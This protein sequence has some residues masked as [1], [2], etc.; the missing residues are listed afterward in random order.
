MFGVD[1]KAD[2]IRFTKAFL[3]NQFARLTPS[4]YVKYTKETGRGLKESSA[5]ETA[6]YF[7]LC[8]FEYFKYLNISE[9]NIPEYL[10]DKYI[11]EYGPGDLP[12]VAILFYAW[13]AEKV[14]CVDRFPLMIF[15][16]FNVA[17]LNELLRQLPDKQRQRAVECFINKNNPGSGLANNHI[18]Y[19]VS[20]N[21]LSGLHSKIDLICSR[22]VLEHVNNL[23]ATFKDMESA[24]K[25]GGHAIHK[26]DLK[27]H[28]LHRTN[29][30]D[31]LTWPSFMWRLMYS[32]KG[33]PNRWRINEYQKLVSMTK[34]D[35]ELIQVV[36]NCDMET[37][38]QVRSHLP[39]QFKDLSNEE[40]RCLSF[41]LLLGK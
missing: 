11:L 26:V 28:G 3:T 2:F 33:A 24:L 31:F 29:S 27:S 37:V 12:G 20:K 41:W 9:D 32:Q 13:G 30:L 38:N 22:A 4:L 8:F 40:L 1:K 21:G 7:I 15:S 19:I 17:V 39:N 25:E 35:L 18:E 14:Y 5:E 34:L 23:L 36:E 16:N 6:R 10:K